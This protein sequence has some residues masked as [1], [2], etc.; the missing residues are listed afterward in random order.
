MTSSFLEE[1]SQQCDGAHLLHQNISQLLDGE[2]AGAARC[3]AVTPPCQQQT[4]EARVEG[5][6][7]V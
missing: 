7:L 4:Q 5:Q 3:Q 1:L 2:V 6:Q